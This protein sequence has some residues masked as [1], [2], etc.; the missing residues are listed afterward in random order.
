[1]HESV[2]F[3][4]YHGE[5]GLYW[6]VRDDDGALLCAPFGPYETVQAAWAAA[7]ANRHFLATAA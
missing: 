6:Q 1:M 5:R 7:P 2:K 3:L 4:N